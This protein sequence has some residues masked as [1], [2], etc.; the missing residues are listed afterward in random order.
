MIEKN[1]HLLSSQLLIIKFSPSSIE[2]QDVCNLPMFNKSSSSSKSRFTVFS[3]SHWKLAVENIVASSSI[4][5]LVS[6]LSTSGACFVLFPLR[7]EPNIPYH[8]QKKIL[9]SLSSTT[10]NFYITII[11][12]FFSPFGQ[13][14]QR[15]AL[16]VKVSDRN[17]KL[18]WQS[19]KT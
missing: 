13:W 9:K 1:N 2:T 11:I 4:I 6:S 10:N 8:K 17:C 14:M 19:P 3:E 5:S 7:T 18:G 16:L 12:P 15:Q